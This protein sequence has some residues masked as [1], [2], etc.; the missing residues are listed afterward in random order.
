MLRK[1]VVATNNVDRQN[2]IIADEFEKIYM[3]ARP[4]VKE[5]FEELERYLD[6]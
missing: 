1:Q 6:E 5:I 3:V 2:E 4:N